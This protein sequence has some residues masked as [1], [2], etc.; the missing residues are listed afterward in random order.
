MS[1]CAAAPVLYLDIDDTLVSWRGGSPHAGPGAREFLLAALDRYEVRW[2]TTWCPTGA[3]D[4]DL[5]S[6]LSRM[7]QIEVPVL[8]RIGGFDWEG[9]SKLDGIAWLEH[10]V[11]GRPYVWVEDEYGFGEGERAFLT[12]HRML[13]RYRCVNVTERPHSLRRVHDELM[14]R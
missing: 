13:D 3:M 5:L 6:D 1:T 7:L 12:A 8:R 14:E 4:D 9:L 10:L 2:L 11:L